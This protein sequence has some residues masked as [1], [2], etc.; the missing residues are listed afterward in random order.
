MSTMQSLMYHS[1]HVNTTFAF[2]SNPVILNHA[3]ETF[4][5]RCIV[6]GALVAGGWS[7]KFLQKLINMGLISRG[8][9]SR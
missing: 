8:E 4:T 1:K 2:K 7:G 5:L 3:Y 9:F 6:Q